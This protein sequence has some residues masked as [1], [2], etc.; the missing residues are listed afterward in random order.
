MI[1]EWENVPS[2]LD[3]LPGLIPGGRLTL[4]ADT[5]VTTSDVTGAGTI[6]Y[7]P[8]TSTGGGHNRI[9]LYNGLR[10]NLYSFSEISLALTLTDAKNYDI[11]IYDNA[12]TLTLELSAA[13]TNDTTRAT[14]LTTQDG[15]CVKSG[16]LTRLYLGTI[17]ASG[18]N[19]TEDSFVG[20]SQSG[21][22]RYV[23]NMYNRVV[24]H[25]GVKDTTDTWTYTTATWRQVNAAAGN[26]VE[27]VVGLS[28]DLIEAF[29]WHNSATSSNIN[30]ATGVGVDSTT[31]N[32]ALTCGAG[33]VTS[34]TQGPMS[35][36]YFGYPGIG[37]HALNWLEISTAAGTTTWVGDNG[38]T[39][40]QTGLQALTKG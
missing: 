10:W 3:S 31:V 34:A 38:V 1:R 13:W 29:A 17:R 19:T 20:G 15:V 5:W 2:L 14:A 25:M 28:E 23:W 11:F 30:S 37:Y 40:R 39:F 36:Y 8:G 21:G 22:K 33:Q 32:S 16:A 35:A 9:A 4:T 27:F 26:K 12:G 6:Y 7:T 18:I 24:R